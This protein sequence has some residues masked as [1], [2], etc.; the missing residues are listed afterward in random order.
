MTGVEKHL[1]GITRLKVKT[2]KKTYF[3]WWK[4]NIGIL[5]SLSKCLMY[6]ENLLEAG[7]GRDTM[8][9]TKAKYLLQMFGPKFCTDSQSWSIEGAAGWAPLTASLGL[10][11]PV[12]C[13]SWAQGAEQNP[14]WVP[15]TGEGCMP[16]NMPSCSFSMSPWH[17]WNW[18]PPF[19]SPGPLPIALR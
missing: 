7:H 16:P 5:A 8:V 3:L 4:C 12:H 9:I 19:P 17:G 15:W 14:K 10:T 2:D 11:F 6:T 1:G 18:R 13:G